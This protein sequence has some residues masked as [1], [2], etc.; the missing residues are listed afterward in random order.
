M[1]I[2]DKTKFTQAKSNFTPCLSRP[3]LTLGPVNSYIM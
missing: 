3:G 1:P 2:S